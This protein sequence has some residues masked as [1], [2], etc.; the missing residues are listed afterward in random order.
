[1]IGAGAMASTARVH[2]APVRVRNRVV[3]AAKMTCD[4]GI[5]AG[6]QEADCI[7]SAG[8]APIDGIL[9]GILL[10]IMPKTRLQ[11]PY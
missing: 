4:R 8:D 3:F 1:M 7:A 2:R 5:S 11:S 10:Q 9:G 6:R